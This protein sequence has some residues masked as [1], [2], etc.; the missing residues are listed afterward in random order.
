MRALAIEQKLEETNTFDR[1]AKLSEKG[2]LKEDFARGLA[3][4]LDYL[5][6]LRLDAQIAV[7]DTTNLFKPG[8]LT[9]M[10]RDLLRDSFQQVKQ[11][12]DL[13]RRRFHLNMF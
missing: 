9:S 10:E 6:T 5:L 2:L 7:S 13:V 3:Q 4:A 11:L 1:L 12:R 8:A